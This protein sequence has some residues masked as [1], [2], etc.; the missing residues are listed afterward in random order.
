MGNQ[1]QLIMA[2]LG[3]IALFAICMLGLVY[4][5]QLLPPSPNVAALFGVCCGGKDPSAKG[6]RMVG[7]TGVGVEGGLADRD[8]ELP[9]A[10]ARRI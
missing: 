5:L 7:R 10:S 3:A 1:E 8:R 2:G 6:V 9:G 4:V